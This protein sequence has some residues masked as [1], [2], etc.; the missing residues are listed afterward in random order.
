MLS[1]YLDKYKK[2][3]KIEES[4]TK[5]L[6]VEIA[7]GED[8]MGEGYERVVFLDIEATIER[9]GGNEAFYKRLLVKLLEQLEEP[10]FD[11][12]ETVSS[13]SSTEIAKRVHTLKGVSGNMGAVVLYDELVAF[14]ASL[15]A[16]SPD[17]NIY[18][19]LIKAYQDTKRVIREYLK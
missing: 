2:G 11:F 5:L 10:L 17:E 3:V 6:L 13:E 7:K 8:E 16:G 9:V 15:K 19:R 12:P 18:E 14:E 1:E 4:V